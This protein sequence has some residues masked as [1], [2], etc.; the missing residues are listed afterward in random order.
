MSAPRP[1]RVGGR[2]RTGRSRGAARRP[3]QCSARL[4]AAPGAQREAWASAYSAPCR[5]RNGVCPEAVGRPL[6]PVSP[7]RSRTRMHCSLSGWRRA[8]ASPWWT[9]W[10]ACRQW[11]GRTW[12]QRRISVGLRV[13]LPQPRRPTGLRLEANGHP[14]FQLPLPCPPRPHRFRGRRSIPNALRTA[15]IE[16]WSAHRA[17]VS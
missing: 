11:V 8:E 1:K 3:T 10:L 15:A 14:T 16:D 9:R 13:M 17:K 5:R 7:N 6:P 12:L 2:T 4:G